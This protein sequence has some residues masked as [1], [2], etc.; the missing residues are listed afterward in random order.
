MFASQTGKDRVLRLVQTRGASIVQSASTKE[1]RAGLLGPQVART[2]IKIRVDGDMVPSNSWWLI[3][4][5]RSSPDSDDWV[6][7][8]IEPIWIQGFS[9]P[10][11]SK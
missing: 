10:A 6:A 3:D 9:N 8:Y 4:W 1:V 5:N 11:G 2:Q 7:V